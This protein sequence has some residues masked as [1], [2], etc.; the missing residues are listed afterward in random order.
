MLR[1]RR[2]HFLQRI[3][4]DLSCCINNIIKN[5]HIVE[6]FACP[7]VARRR[8]LR[9]PLALAVLA[10]LRD[11]LWELTVEEAELRRHC[12]V[13]GVDN[14]RWQQIFR[15][16]SSRLSSISF[17]CLHA[18]LFGNKPSGRS[19]SV[20]GSTDFVG[21][22]RT[23]EEEE[24]EALA[25]RAALLSWLS[26]SFLLSA[27]PNVI[28]SRALHSTYGSWCSWCCYCISFSFVQTSIAWWSTSIWL[29]LLPYCFDL[30]L[31]KKVQI[32]IFIV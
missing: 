22:R 7:I 8:G 3:D 12:I 11:S 25:S 17:L 23:W 13:S 31:W 19:R 29:S 26:R 24:E 4:P 16:S 32:G 5:A 20:L 18:P 6:Q 27:C 15:L 10:A 30:I 1:V 28:I 9:E 21:T 2:S 14:R